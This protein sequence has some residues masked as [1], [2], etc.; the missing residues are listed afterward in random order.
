MGAS[1]DNV[2]VAGYNVYRCTP[3]TAGQPC[4][5]IW[6]ANSTLPSFND[7]TLTTNTVV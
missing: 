7:T 1:T 3:P 6:I 2:G 5:G 4:T